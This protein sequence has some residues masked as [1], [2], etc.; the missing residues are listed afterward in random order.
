M[1]YVKAAC[2]LITN[3]YI[4]DAIVCH[5]YLN[6]LAVIKQ[7]ISKEDYYYKNKM[8]KF[9]KRL[10]ILKY[11]NKFFKINFKSSVM[12]ENLVTTPEPK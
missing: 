8:P 12:Y 11:L 1:T 7:K 6:N 9:S 10:L 2:T 5:E 3:N 4:A